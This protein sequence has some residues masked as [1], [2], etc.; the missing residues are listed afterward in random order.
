MNNNFDNLCQLILLE[1]FN[2]CVGSE[3]RTHIDE[4]SAA[5]SDAAARMAD[6]YA[7]AHKTLVLS[8]SSHFQRAM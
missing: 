6:E 2:N 8:P 1:D 3:I 5:T 7:L 4:Q